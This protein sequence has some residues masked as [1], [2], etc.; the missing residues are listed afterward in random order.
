MATI[1]DLSQKELSSL[2]I[3]E[4]IELLRNIRLSR[5]IVKKSS[6]TKTKKVKNKK[7][8][9]LTPKQAGELLK[10]LGGRN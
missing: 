6:K 8:K 2:S 10:I 5:R 7:Q 9:N 3:D 1:N 4:A